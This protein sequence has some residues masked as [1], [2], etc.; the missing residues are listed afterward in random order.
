MALIDLN[1][2]PVI[3]SGINLFYGLSDFRTKDS[4]SDSPTHEPIEFAAREAAEWI[5]Y[6]KQLNNVTHDLI[7][8]SSTNTI[9]L[10]ANSNT[11]SGINTSLI[12]LNTYASGI[13]T[14][15]IGLNTYASGIENRLRQLEDRVFAL[16]LLH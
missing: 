13:N 4:A 11:T 6:F 14:S 9:N 12:G 2:I 7:S 15:L 8:G 16:E 3:T 5:G 1:A 10:T